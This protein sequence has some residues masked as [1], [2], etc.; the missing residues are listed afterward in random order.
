MSKKKSPPEQPPVTEAATPD[1]HVRA[2]IAGVAL[3]ALALA[4]FTGVVFMRQH[5]AR[6]P[7]RLETPAPVAAA[8]EPAPWTYDSVTNQHWDPAHKHWHSGHPP[9]QGQPGGA[10]KPMPDIPNP[11][12]WQYDA[13]TDQH[14]NPE[15]GHNHWH[16]G[17][18]PADKVA[19]PI[20][21]PEP[22]PAPAPIAVQE[23]AEAATPVT[24]IPAAEAPVPAE[25]AP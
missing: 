12:P 17:K 7:I 6:P 24:E 5:K 13:A 22:N 10:P 23:A 1:F 3:V 2:W 16:N 25:A 9:A 21:G 4:G 15:A 20:P 18:P 11:Q 8:P 19:T 14:F